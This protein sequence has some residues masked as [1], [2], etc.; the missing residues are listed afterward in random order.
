MAH[1]PTTN[2]GHNVRRR[3]QDR[4][5]TLEAL[6]ELSG[7]SPTMLSE[8]ERG[9][10]NPTVRLAWQVARALGCSLT[11]LLEPQASPPV[12]VVRADERRSLVDPETG[13]ERHG[14]ATELLRRGLEVVWYVLPARS[15]TGEMS[16]NRPGVLEHAIVLDGELTLR[17]GEEIHHLGEGDNV[18]YGARTLVE[19]RNET[20][21]G[22]E[23]L[24]LSDT[25]EAG[26]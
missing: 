20:D 12:H 2:I 11:D 6:A 5:L 22:C 16:P 23:F 24:L 19:Y 10:K 4:G 18:T 25:S 9:I 17:L 8:V 14:L 21:V 26:R 1:D 13:V 15:G 7:V 3:R